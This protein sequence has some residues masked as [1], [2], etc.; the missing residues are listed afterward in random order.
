MP[1][2]DDK[3]CCRYSESAAAI[4]V[5]LEDWVTAHEDDRVSYVDCSQLYIIDSNEV[6]S[7]SLLD[8]LSC[9]N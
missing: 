3:S 4:N 7:H 9:Q 2:L 6:G 8:T 5:I 1:G